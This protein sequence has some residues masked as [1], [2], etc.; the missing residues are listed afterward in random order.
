MPL[1]PLDT[2]HADELAALLTQNR[3]FLAPWEPERP[4]SFFTAR[5]Q[6]ERIDAAAL[7]RD[8]DLGYA[9]VI[10]DDSGALQ[11]AISINNVV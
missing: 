9:F 11:G 1:V 6:R 7:N 3:A 10:T 5:G 8:L 2:H 4:D